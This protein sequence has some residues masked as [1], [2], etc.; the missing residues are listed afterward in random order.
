MRV[1]CAGHVN[2]DV[3]LRVDRLPAPDDEARVRERSEAGGGSAANV[4]TALV[5]LEQQ[6]RLLGSV[7]D[8]DTGERA[9][10]DLRASGVETRVEVVTDLETTTKYILVDDD[11]EVAILGTDGAN[12][13]L[14]PDDIDPAVFEDADALHLTAQR[15]ET[16]ARL[17]ELATER[18]LPVS[19]DPG[20]RL[21]DRSYDTVL[22]QADVLFVTER[23]AAAID[24]SVPWLVTKR[25]EAG[26][27]LA[28]PDG[29]YE[30]PGYDL[31]SVDSTGAGDA[32]AAGFLA[33]WLDDHDPERALGTANACGAIAASERGPKTALSWGRIE[34]VRE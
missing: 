21:P 23:E 34:E 7:G 26:A 18:D 25:G 12:E 5:A 29:R 22:E 27:T 14:A 4:A 32:F 8:D 20:R 24:A 28:C 2:W 30:H 15:P 11:A 31:P 19:F 13:A 1:V 9:L 10:A 3:T 17:A 16:A 6:A 33:V